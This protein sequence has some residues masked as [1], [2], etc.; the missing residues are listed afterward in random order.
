M[1]KKCNF[2]KRAKKKFRV[3]LL[4]SLYIFVTSIYG[5]FELIKLIFLG[6]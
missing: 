2:C 3:G 1:K 5:T 6:S 4:V